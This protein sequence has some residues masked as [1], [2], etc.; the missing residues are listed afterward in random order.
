MQKSKKNSNN[1]KRKKT[2][3]FKIY[4]LKYG[5]QHVSS[6]IKMYIESLLKGEKAKVI[7]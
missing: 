4:Q 6:H 2:K 1:N 5:R 7:E 3:T